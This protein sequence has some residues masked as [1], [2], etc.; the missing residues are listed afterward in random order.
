V[1]HTIIILTTIEVP[2]HGLYIGLNDSYAYELTV[3]QVQLIC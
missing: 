1:K 2:L 3:N